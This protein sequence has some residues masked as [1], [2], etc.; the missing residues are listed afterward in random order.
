MY[1]LCDPLLETESGRKMTKVAV[2]GIGQSLRGD[3][4]A[5]LEAVR[6]WQEKFPETAGRPDI[7]IEASELPGL[8]LL[9]MLED[10]D[11]AILVDAVH[12]SSPSGT[13]HRLD[14]KDLSAFTSDAKSAHGWGVA[15]TL[16]MGRLLGKTGNIPIRLIGIEA[17]QTILG[18]GM[19][20]RMQDNIPFVC[21]IIQK[22][23]EIILNK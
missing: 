15:E 10:V 21:E 13:I 2:I 16:D 17:E 1:F 11:A 4:A 5:G 3:D 20:Q 22:E 7:R 19:S 9:D 14:E 12:S 8:A 23:V 18:T 6:Q